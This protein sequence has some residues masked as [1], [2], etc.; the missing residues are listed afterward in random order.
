LRKSE[1]VVISL[2][3]FKVGSRKPQQARRH[4]AM[5]RAT[6]AATALLFTTSFLLFLYAEVPHLRNAHRLEGQRVAA[7]LL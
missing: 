3:R 2:F 7:F 5:I 1:I 4:A 6:E